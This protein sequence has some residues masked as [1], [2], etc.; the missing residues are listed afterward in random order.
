M[1]RS[2]AL[3]RALRVL[4][5]AAL[6]CLAAAGSA[7]PLVLKPA[8]AQVSWGTG[9]KAIAIGAAALGLAFAGL[10]RWRK[11]PAQARGA[12]PVLAGSRRVSQ[13]TVLLVVHW[14]GKAYLLSET[15]SSLQLLDSAALE[16]AP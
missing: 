16:E 14:R 9:L 12:G 10:S 8:Q 6:L 2:S 13:K 3:S 11:R 5:A 4:S 7:Q 1:S 15:G